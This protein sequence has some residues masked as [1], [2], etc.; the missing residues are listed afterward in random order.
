MG[1]VYEDLFKGR[2]VKLFIGVW[3]LSFIWERV[4]GFDFT[5]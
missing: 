4:I 5:F 3:L 2:L 1:S